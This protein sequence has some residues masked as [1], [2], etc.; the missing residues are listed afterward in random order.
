MMEANTQQ[1][2]LQE[3]SEVE[4]RIPGPNTQQSYAE[5]H[6]SREVEYL[7][8]TSN[9][10]GSI[11]D[12]DIEY[13][14]GGL[15]AYLVVL[16]SF[17]GAVTC[18]GIINSVGAIQ[19]YVSIHQLKD[20]SA[21]SISWI[22]SI[23][24]SLTYALGLFTGPIF[25]YK[26]A[27]MLLLVATL[28]IF[29]GL[30][31]AASS[32]K[33]YHFILSFI[34]LGIGNGVGLTPVIG[35]LN[36]WF[37]KKRGFVTGLV[38]SGGSVGGLCFPLLLRFLFDKYGYVLALRI[39]AFIG[40]ACMLIALFTLK[41]RVL[42]LKV[43]KDRTENPIV[44]WK[45]NGSLPHFNHLALLDQLSKATRKHRDKTFVL[46]IVGAFCTELSLV[47]I[48]TYFV[49]YIIAQGIPESTGYLLLAIWNA[50]STPGR[51]IPGIISDHLG[52]F[53][54]HIF[55]IFGESVCIF[56]IW[57]AFGHN[58]NALYVYSCI[59]GFFQGLISGMIP[60]CLAQ[61]SAVSEFGERY[62]LL[63]F[64]LSFGNLIVIPI[65]AAIIDDG[66]VHNYNM[67]VVL[68][69]CLMVTGT[70][71][72]YLSRINMVG[73]SLKVKV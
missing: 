19:A 11:N 61:I 6:D 42:R 60:A 5:S 30:M 26:G 34:C 63:N 45:R 68:V 23:Y 20:L 56:A 29:G 72:Y 51:I 38:T 40:G 53:N 67:F 10:S 37:L 2:E 52:K 18:L 73:M 12:D 71:F 36:H 7:T 31:G 44:V 17:C 50:C 25:D 55:M 64:F 46:S 33:V 58:L 65:G 3:F 49:T 24:L 57:L 39:L 48:V 1:V 66:S 16:G 9:Y 59:G 8:A 41:E 62:G 27:R 47:L 35:V 32:T 15:R 43:S 13:P 14:D 21:A 4:D 70:L 69:G 54:V 28:F 22:F